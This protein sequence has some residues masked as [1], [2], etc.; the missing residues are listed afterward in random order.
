MI[1]VFHLKMRFSEIKYQQ[2]SYQLIARVCLAY[3]QHL[4]FIIEKCCEY[5]MCEH[6]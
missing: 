6:H 3:A 5:M 4:L 1:K 2:N